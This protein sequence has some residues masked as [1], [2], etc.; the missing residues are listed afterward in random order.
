[1]KKSL[2]LR[3]FSNFSQ[4]L[5]FSFFYQKSQIFLITIFSD[6]KWVESN[7]IDKN[8]YEMNESKISR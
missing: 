4:F 5:F 6:V 2:R 8:K 7:E 1:V 3:Y